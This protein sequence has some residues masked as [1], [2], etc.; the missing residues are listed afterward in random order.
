M[1]FRVTVVGLIRAVPSRCPFVI[2]SLRIGGRLAEDSHMIRRLLTSST[3]YGDTAGSDR[4]ELLNLERSTCFQW[5]GG[6]REVVRTPAPSD[7]IDG[8]CALPD[9]GKTKQ[10]NMRNNMNMRMSM[11]I[12]IDRRWGVRVIIIIIVI[13][14]G[15]QCR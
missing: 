13:F 6:S 8:F 4:A 2:N 3:T 11:I 14:G 5:F 10:N 12:T 9:T 15:S 7:D 1:K